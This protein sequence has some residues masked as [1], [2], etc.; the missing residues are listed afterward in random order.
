MPKFYR[1]LLLLEIVKGK[2]FEYDNIHVQ[3]ELK[4]PKY[5]KVLE[6][7]DELVGSTHS[8]LKYDGS[9]NFGHCHCLTLDIENELDVS[10]EGSMIRIF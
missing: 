5:V 1:I 8:S 10:E 6:G 4:L 3:Y 7:K 9:W 2:G